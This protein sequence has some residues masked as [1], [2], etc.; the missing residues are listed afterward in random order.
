MTVYQNWQRGGEWRYSFYVF[1]KRHHGPCLDQDGKPVTS[2][3]DAKAARDREKVAARQRHNLARSGIRAGNFTL[4]QAAVR[5]LVKK[6]GKT[7]FENHKRYVREIKAFGNFR[8]GAIAMRDIGQED[9]DAYAAFAAKQTLKK[10]IG[11]HRRKPTGTAADDRYWKDTGKA[12]SKREVNNYLKCLRSLFAI[13][14]KTRDPITKQPVIDGLPEIP[15][16]KMPKR[17]P[18]PIGDDELSA[19]LEAAPPWAQDKGELAR[20]FGLRLGETTIVSRRHIYR[21]T[22]GLRF[23]AGETKSGNEE[24]V[25]GGEAGWQLLQRLEAQA[26]ERGQEH[27]VTWAGPKYWRA[28]LRGEEVPR[29]AWRPVKSIKRSWKTTIKAAEIDNPHRFHDVRA[30]YVTEVARVMPAAAQDA[31]RHQDPSTTAM[32]IKL[33]SMEIRDAVAQAVARRAIRP[34][35]KVVK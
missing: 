11:G 7:D 27:L 29:E 22:Q 32:Y 10:W 2:K 33:A 15:L 25:H 16:F 30:Q 17:L 8:G 20:L 24:L 3:R 28:H 12:R 13:A 21:P 1:K 4:A 5:H 9:C 19:R 35:F 18:R 34:K 14:D 6:E 23:D 26:I 31:A